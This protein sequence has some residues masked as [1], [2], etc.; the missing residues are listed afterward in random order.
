VPYKIAGVDRE[1][2]SLG[3]SLTREAIVQCELESL[4]LKV[5]FPII[6]TTPLLTALILRISLRNK[7]RV[8]F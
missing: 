2:G 6:M 1:C 7:T 8:K 5:V 4:K 3:D